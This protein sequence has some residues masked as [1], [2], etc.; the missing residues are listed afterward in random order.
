MSKIIKNIT[1]W[2][3]VI[4]IQMIATVVLGFFV[5]KLGALPTMYLAIILAVLLLLLVGTFFLMK[6]SKKKN[7]NKK[8]VREYA[9]KILSLLLSIVMLI[10]TIYIA[11]GDSTLSSI[12]GAN[13]QTNRFVVMVLNNSPYQ[14]L[15]DL[16]NKTVEMSNMYD[17]EQ[18][19]NDSKNALLD[20]NKN[21]N[22]KEINDYLQLAKDLYTEKVD[23]IYVNEG[24]NGMFEE[25]YPSFTADVRIIWS[26]DITE[27]I[28]DIKKEVNVTKDVFTI[29]ISGI[30]TTGKVSTVSRSDVNML[31]T[32]NPVTKD[33]LMTSIPR[34]YYVTLAN[35]G[36]KDKLTHAGLGGVENSVKTIE[37]FMNI[38]I[39]Y[40]ARVNF[41]SLIKIV[42]ALGGIEVESPY[43]F[44][45]R[46]YNVKIE[47]GINYL[48]GEEALGFVR[49]RY[50]LPNGDGDRVQNQ[51]RVLKGMLK[52]AMSPSIIS[53]YSGLLDAIDGSFET[54]M[55]SDDIMKLIKMQ[56]N[57]MS[58]WNFHSTML[59]GTGKNMTGGAYM[60]NNKLYYLVPDQNSIDK[61]SALIKQMMK[62]EKISVQ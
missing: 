55:T 15:D 46:H 35:K 28:V 37:D 8:S 48:N 49:E 22:I 24:Y 10:G 58:S 34:D 5:V 38:D 2:Q 1:K 26:H 40:Y 27:E 14:D 11:K 21:I 41:T 47:K 25:I 61:C 52:K 50:S 36:K 39:N 20:E 54:N 6:P 44:T 19:Y 62:G 33:I 53:N 31:V 7:K 45:T 17:T 16:T 30:D 60:P 12:T 9:G 29:F 57:D 59:T 18:N 51:Q 42:D 56:L 43:S 3:V 13:E 32:V 23:A 4:A